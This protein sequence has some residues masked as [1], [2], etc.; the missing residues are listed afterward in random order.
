MNVQPLRGRQEAR[1]VTGA[2]SYFFIML[3]QSRDGLKEADWDIDFYHLD[4]HRPWSFCAPLS[5][6]GSC[7][8][9]NLAGLFNCLYWDAD[10]SRLVPSWKRASQKVFLVTWDL[11]KAGRRHSQSLYSPSLQ[12]RSPFSDAVYP[13]RKSAHSTAAWRSTYRPFVVY[14]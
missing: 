11:D 7:C 10:T 12:D 8:Y 3:W 1:L 13:A 6:P 9:R 14:F 5:P 4:F 2:H